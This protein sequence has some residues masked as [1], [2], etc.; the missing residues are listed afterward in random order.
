MYT[1]FILKNGDTFGYEILRAGRLFIH[2]I[3]S[4]NF[5]NRKIDSEQTAMQL[6]KLLLAKL[7]LNLSPIVTIEEEEE[8]SSGFITDERINE[9][10]LNYIE[11]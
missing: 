10:V 4:P 8:L 1:Y 5:E 9:I 6:A 3:Q 2:Q 7:D 11:K